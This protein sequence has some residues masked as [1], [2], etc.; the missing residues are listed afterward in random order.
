MKWIDEGLLRLNLRY[1]ILD[2]KGKVV[3]YSFDGMRYRMKDKTVRSLNYDKIVDTLLTNA[4]TIKP[5]DI[6]GKKVPVLI[7]SSLP[8]YIF[9]VENHH[10]TW[11]KKAAIFGIEKI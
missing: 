1:I 2:E 11:C 8:E 6:N 10:I 7:I 9:N 3:Y 4:P 5:S